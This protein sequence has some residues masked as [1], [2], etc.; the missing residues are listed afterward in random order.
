MADEKN[1]GKGS[2]GN[3]RISKHDAWQER[4]LEK[5][6]RDDI[7]VISKRTLDQG[8][9]INIL[10]SLDYYLYQLRMNMGR[11]K[12]ITFDKAQEF[13]ERSQRIKEDI[14]LLNAEMCGL[15]GYTYKPPKG[16]TNPLVTMDEKEKAKKGG[17]TKASA[18]DKMTESAVSTA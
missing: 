10:N 8:D 4:K 2:Q 15:M 14:N 5:A 18:A 17:S 9:F 16:F 13:I 6:K 1:N 7:D 12:V 11:I 3:D